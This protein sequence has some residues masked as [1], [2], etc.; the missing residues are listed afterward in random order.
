MTVHRY[1][2]AGQGWPELLDLPRNAV[3]LKVVAIVKMVK[4]KE[5]RSLGP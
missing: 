4:P 5:R 1:R 2:L 3:T